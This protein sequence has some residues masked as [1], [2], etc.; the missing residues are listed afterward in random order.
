MP[1]GSITRR[2]ALT[3]AGAFGAAGLSAT[4]LAG[5]AAAAPAALDLSSPEAIS[6]A[7]IKI[8]GSIAE[9][10]VTTFQRFHIYGDP[11]GGNLVPL[12][13]MNN[14]HIDEWRPIER[15]TY[16]LRHYEVGYYTVFDSEEPLET[17][18]NPFTDEEIEIFHFRLG[19]IEREYRPSEIIAP[20]LPPNPLTLNVIGDRVFLPT[21]SIN[22]FANF[23]TPEDY[24][25]ESSGEIVFY[26]SLFTYSAY[27]ADVANPDVT[28]APNHCH[29]QNAVSWAPWMR[30]AGRPG[31]ST[32]QG[33]GCK[34]PDLAALPTH[35][36][37][38]FE[39]YT[40]EIFATSEWNEV[41]FEAIDYYNHLEAKKG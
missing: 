10:T 17:W 6:E 3:G 41:I 33:F 30:M 22:E 18:T 39:T 38:G 29:L 35:V 8:V 21:S 2:N 7:R 16:A 13:S 4:G 9:E 20:A 19:P 34:I 31:R 12:F 32:V 40:P 25:M 11:H 23:F 28:S 27:V 5:V 1:T 36:R 15:G 26:D 37:K 24:P 14:L